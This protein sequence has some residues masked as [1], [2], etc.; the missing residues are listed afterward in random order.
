MSCFSCQS[1]NYRMSIHLHCLL[2]AIIF[3]G[4]KYPK[5]TT[6]SF[7]K[8]PRIHIVSITPSINEKNKIKTNCNDYQCRQ[9]QDHGDWKMAIVAAKPT[10]YEAIVCTVLLKPQMGK[11]LEWVPR[12]TKEGENSYWKASK[13]PMQG[14]FYPWL[15][16]NSNL[17]WILRPLLALMVLILKRSVSQWRKESEST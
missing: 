16:S 13:G 2:T 5:P 8:N 12:L 7:D 15:V 6:R 14:Q 10:W 17:P 1:H 4:Y 3:L 9:K 11:L